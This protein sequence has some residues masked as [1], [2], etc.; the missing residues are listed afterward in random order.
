MTCTRKRRMNACKP[1]AVGD[2]DNASEL[3]KF[4]EQLRTYTLSGGAMTN[5]VGARKTEEQ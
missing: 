5:G 1:D 4:D 3:L 2:V